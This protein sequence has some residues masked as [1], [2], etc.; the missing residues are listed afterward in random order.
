MNTRRSFLQR[1]MAFGAGALSIPAFA[2]AEVS[3]DSSP[4]RSGAH[5][6]SARRHPIGS[7]ISV[8]TPDISNL[9][10]TMDN[11]VKVFHLVAEPVKQEILP[12][13]V[14]DLWGFNGSAPG[15]TIQVNQGDRAR[16][17]VDNH[18]P[19]PTSMHW[20]GFEIPFDMDGGPGVSQ[21]PI[22]PGGRFVYEFTLHQEGTYFYHSHMAM[23][24]M[25]GMLGGFIM[26]PKE[27]HR[28]EV[29]KDFLV[30]L[31]EYAVLPSS[32]V[33]NSMNMEFNWL[34]ING[35]A[36][37]AN[38]PLIVRLGDRVRIRVINLGMDHHPIHLHGHTFQVT[39]TEAGRIP[40]SARFPGNTVL[41]GVAQSRDIEFVANNPGPWMLHCH[42]PHHMMNQMSSTVGLLTRT[43]KG[44]PAGVSMENGMG[45]LTGEPGVPT[46]DEYG[47]SL[48]RGMG[49]FYERP[50]PEQWTTFPDEQVAGDARHAWHEYE[51]ANRR[52]RPKCK[53]RSW[54][55]ARRFHGRT[56]DGFIA[57]KMV[58][59]VSENYDLPAGW[60]GFMQGMMTFVRVLPPDKYDEVMRRVE[61][62]EKPKTPDMPVMR[63]WTQRPTYETR[64]VRRS[65]NER[66]ILSNKCCAALHPRPWPMACNKT[67]CSRM[68]MPGNHRLRESSAKL[69]HRR[70]CKGPTLPRLPLY[71]SR[72]CKSPIRVGSNLPVPDLLV[73]AKT[74][75][76][77]EARGFRKFAAL[78]TNPT[79]KQALCCRLW[80]S[81]GLARQAGL[82]PNPAI[83]YQGEQI[84]GGS[85]HG[86]EQGVSLCSARTLFS[87]ESFISGNRCMSSSTRL[88]KLGLTNSG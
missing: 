78:K 60:S 55:S 77:H 67:R 27:P 31:Q 35:K 49:V 22:K 1:A 24:E 7:P 84:R 41:V 21:Y 10:Y 26:H 64:N 79:L 74:V 71:M 12:G 50:T 46:G 8:V 6:D 68:Q 42:L 87:G 62:G 5:S 36:G 37:P 30:A 9:A 20:H 48:G 51:S 4:S 40:D 19:E 83:G 72:D 45:M 86:G 25:M 18:L 47:P 14:L 57:D 81:A 15:P 54:V 29:D 85:F 44:V 88:M 75:P 43:G 61:S 59:E 58:S 13:K 2:R 63:R 39:G 73:E 28:P 32:V 3:N 11:A 80:T 82:W 16:I 70:V 52:H 38:T 65:E 66:T 23:Q 56:D 17:I 33:P 76:T 53:Q 69:P 34:V